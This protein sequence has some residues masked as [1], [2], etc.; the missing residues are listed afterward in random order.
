[1][2]FL[3]CKSTGAERR[4]L[5]RHAILVSMQPA[6]AGLSDKKNEVGKSALGK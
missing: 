2:A 4:S 1:M 6:D 3:C 5:R